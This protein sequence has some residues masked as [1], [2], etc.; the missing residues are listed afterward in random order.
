MTALRVLV[1]SGRAFRTRTP[2]DFWKA[3]VP[4]NI[5]TTLKARAFLSTN[6]FEFL[7]RQHNIRALAINS[8]GFP[9]DMTSLHSPTLLPHLQDLELYD[10]SDWSF[11]ELFRGRSIRVLRFPD[12]YLFEWLRIPDRLRPLT[13]SLTVLD[14]SHGMRGDLWDL[15]NTNRI[16]SVVDLAV[17]LRMLACFGLF[18]YDGESSHNLLLL[19]EF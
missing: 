10:T 3:S 16:L 9:S 19:L 6:L 11:L 2:F 15:R 17:N 13:A 8:V 12:A 7:K 14:L 18:I 5:L 1:I 4:E